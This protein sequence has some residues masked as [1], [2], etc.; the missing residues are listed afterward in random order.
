M[1]GY[2]TATTQ[3]VKG[4]TLK[5]FRVK[6]LLAFIAALSLLTSCGNGETKLEGVLVFHTYTDYNAWDSQLKL[7]DLKTGKLIIL[8]EKWNVIHAINGHFSPDGK[9]LTFMGSAKGLTEP[10]WDV[11]VS[12]WDGQKWVE[13][14]NLTG[15]NGKRDEDPKFN[16]NNKT[17]VYKEDGVL[18]TINIDRTNLTYLTIGEAE[19]SMPY[20]APNGK[21]IL[22][23]RNG[24]ILLL[25]DGNTKVLSGSSGLK[26]Y[27]P[28]GVDDKKFLFTQIQENKH[29]RIMW[30]FYNGSEPKPLFFD[31]DAFDTSDAF[32]YKDG[33]EYMFT[34]SGDSKVP[35]GGYNLM[36]V[37]F[38]KQTS[39]NIDDYFGKVNTDL[40]ELGPA[41]SGTAHFPQRR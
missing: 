5:V 6:S 23:E 21:D 17:V 4:S 8:S 24:E 35:L 34:V 36:L 37:D 10:D 28:I 29:D 1:L 33:T 12:N 26:T 2:L 20:F 13:P 22:F 38:K 31:S 14:V 9:H 3:S 11:F 27:Y 39:K 40:Q 30:G 19:S 32:P 16:P 25:R 7:L 41:W 18:A 15:P